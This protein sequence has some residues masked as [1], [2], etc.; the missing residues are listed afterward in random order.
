VA[1]TISDPKLKFKFVDATDILWITYTFPGYDTITI[2]GT[3]M[4]A[5]EKDYHRVWDG[6][7]G[8][9]IP[10]TFLEMTFG[11]ADGGTVFKF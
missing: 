9:M 4:I 2:T 3:Q 8:H 10:T 11:V 7:Q 1:I 5:V 6:T